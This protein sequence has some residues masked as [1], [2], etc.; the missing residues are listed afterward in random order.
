MPVTIREFRRPDRDQL[1]ELVNRHVATVLPGVALSTNVVLSQLEAEPAEL[2]IDQ[3]VAER[4]CLVATQADV[5]VAAT[6]I[7]RYRRDSDVREGYRGAAVLRW[8]IAEPLSVEAGQSLLR[9]AIALAE[10]WEPSH[11]YVDQSLPAPGC[12]GISDTWLICAH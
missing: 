10:R 8:F 12:L 11:L 5:V 9:A 6:L 4:H 1:T 3:W 2:M 7:H